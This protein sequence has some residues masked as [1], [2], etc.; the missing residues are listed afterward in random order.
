[1]KLAFLPI[2]TNKLPAETKKKTQEGGTFLC[3][4]YLVNSLITV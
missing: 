2:N 3:H 1:M 4:Y